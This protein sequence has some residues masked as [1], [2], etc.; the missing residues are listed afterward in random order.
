MHLGLVDL[1][2]VYRPNLVFKLAYKH[3]LCP[4]ASKIVFASV[5]NAT[6]CLILQN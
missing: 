4:I 6:K 3:K 5:S 2:Q 1:F